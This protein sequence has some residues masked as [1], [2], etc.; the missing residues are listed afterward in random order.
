MDSFINWETGET[1]FESQG[2]IDFI[3]FLA[4]CPE[5]GFWEA[6]YDSMGGNYVY[7]EEKSRK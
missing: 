2:F 6:Y 5:K 4:T 1:K 7:D 3:K